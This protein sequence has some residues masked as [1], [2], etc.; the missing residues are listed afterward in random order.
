[1]NLDIYESSI[2]N[3]SRIKHQSQVVDAKITRNLVEADKLFD[4]I[5]V[6]HLIITPEGFY[7]YADEG[8]L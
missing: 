4:I 7:S 1:M 5:V 6:D 3:I 8:R 2:P